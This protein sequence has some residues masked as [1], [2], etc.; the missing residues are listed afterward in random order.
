MNNTF[1]HLTTFSQEIAIVSLNNVNLSVSVMET[2]HSR[3]WAFKYYVDEY[4]E[5]KTIKG[6]GKAI[7]VTGREVAHRAVRR[8]GSHIF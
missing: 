5:R 6:K 2:W 3:N 1:M 7:P 8:R 4:G